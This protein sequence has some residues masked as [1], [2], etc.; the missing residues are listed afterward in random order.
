MNLVF[1]PL[2]AGMAR[3]AFDCGEP[4]LN[5]YLRQQARQDVSRH[6]ATVIIAREA[7]APDSIAGYYT[8]SAASVPF[9]S[10]PIELRR[11]IPRYPD[12]PAIRLGRL[13]VAKAF[14]SRHYGTLLTVDAL[15]RAC[16]SELAWALFCVDAKNERAARF[17]QKM[18]FKPF[19]DRPESLWMQRK[20]AETI[21]AALP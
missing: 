9:S 12:V 14:Q 3:N 16:R 6:F 15:A 17:Y 2:R 5:A 18:M 20:Q 7:S 10:A 11:G 8:L 1:E 13:A 4:A 19:Q 21:I